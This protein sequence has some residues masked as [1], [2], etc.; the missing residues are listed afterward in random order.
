MN[1]I[2]TLQDM[3]ERSD[4]YMYST[5]SFSLG[6]AEMHES[7]E[8]EAIETVRA[9]QEALKWVADND[10]AHPANMV[11]VCKSALRR[12]EGNAG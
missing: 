7:A 1:L 8:I 6:A 11:A 12:A 2:E 4:A 10:F 9:M 3:K 5:G